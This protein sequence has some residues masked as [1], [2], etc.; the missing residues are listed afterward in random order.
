NGGLT[1]D[2]ALSLPEYQSEYGQG[3]GG[4]YKPN[5]EKSYGPKA[6]GHEVTLWNGAKVPYTAHPD[7]VKNFLRTATTINNSVSASGGNEKMRTFFSYGNVKAQGIVRN[8]DMTRHNIDL[9]IDNNL[10]KKLSF[11]TKVSYIYQEIDNMP[12]TGEQG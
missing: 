6:D 2:N 1:F 9:K 5:S 10:S 7:N 11:T 4:E 3:Y 12:H 8:N